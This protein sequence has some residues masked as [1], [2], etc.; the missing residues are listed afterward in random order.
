MG[1]ASIVLTA[2]T[3]VCR[4]TV[5]DIGFVDLSGPDYTLLHVGEKDS[6]LS[7]EALALAHALARDGNVTVGQID[8]ADPRAAVLGSA[9]NGWLLGR[10]GL[11]PLVLATLNEPAKPSGTRN[12]LRA[13][14]HSPLR[15]DALARSLTSFALVV[16]V[17]GRDAAGNDRV[18]AAIAG[19]RED[20]T[21]IA[22]QLP[23]PI[24]QPVV[25]LT[26]EGGERAAE[27]VLLWSLGL[28][29]SD[30]RPAVALLYGRGKLA[31]PVMLGE[32]VSRHEL[33][34]QLALVGESCECDTDRD[35][36]AEPR[37]PMAWTEDQRA[38]AP[39]MLGFD[40]A[41]PLVVAEVARILARGPGAGPL[42]AGRTTGGIEALLLGY[43]EASLE[44]LGPS[45]LGAGDDPRPAD[46]PVR[47][48][49]GIAGDDWSFHDSPSGPGLAE[50]NAEATGNPPVGD[51]PR[52]VPSGGATRIGLPII[53]LLVVV[54]VCLLF[55]LFY[56]LAGQG[57]GA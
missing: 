36:A 18:R 27:A 55:G 10:E 53:A 57:R 26:V 5:R 12:A 35:W 9:P 30:P 48:M 7:P 39:R 13:V 8:R 11:Q 29:P 23:R 6:Q 41:S 17:E 16:S 49:E 1:F 4:Y 20:L 42:R 45:T 28:D 31:G 37:I 47:V 32:G 25:T 24:E 34:A 21:R 56:W 54:A 52:P 50:A 15:D 44:E 46:G 22:G 43:R 38:E 14:L 40:P 3:P 19:A 51:T 33:L 2:L